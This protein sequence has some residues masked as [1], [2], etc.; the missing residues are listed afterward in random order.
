MT[1]PDAHGCMAWIHVVMAIAE[2]AQK[3]KASLYRGLA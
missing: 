3:F 1:L 2:A